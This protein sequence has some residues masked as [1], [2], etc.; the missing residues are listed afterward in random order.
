[1]DRNRIKS[2]ISKMTLEEKASLCSGQDFWHTKRI[3]RLQ[4]PDIMVSDGPSGLRKQDAE[5]D[6]LGVNDSIR[7]VCFP[8]GVTTAAS[9]DLDLME[10]LGRTLGEE[11]Q[12]EDLAILLG[13]AMNIK[14][15]P[16]C[17]RNFEYYSEDPYLSSKLA[18]AY[19]NGL[20]SKQ[21]G[22]CP[23]HFFAN[24]MENHRMTASSEIDERTKREIYLASFEG[25]VKDAKPWSMMCSYNKINGTYAAENEEALSKILRTEWGF[26]GFVMTDWGACNDRVPDL[27]AGLD[28]EMPGSGGA[29]DNKIVKAVKA[30]TLSE[31][32]VDAACERILDIVYRYE[33]HKKTGDQTGIDLKKGHEMAYKVAAN[34][35][36]LLKNEGLLPLRS[37]QQVVFIGKYAQK[38]RY[39]GGGSSHVNNYRIVSALD[40]LKEEASVSF[41]MGYDDSTDEIVEP[42]E[43]EAVKAARNAEAAVLFIGLPNEYESEGYDRKHM[44]LPPNQNHLVEEVCKVQKNVVVVL[45]NGAPVEMPWIGKVGAVLESYLGGQ[46]VGTAQTDIL[47]GKVNPSGHLAESFPI[48]LE[49]NPSYLSF[50]VNHEQVNYMEG[51]Y[52]GYRYYD[53]KN[54]EVLFPFG[55]GLSYTEFVYSDLKISKISMKDTET[56]EVSVT[57][58][59]TGDVYGKEVVQ[60]YVT[61][62]AC[63]VG[64]PE[65]EL[66]GFVKVAL[67]PKESKEVSISLDKRSFAFWNTRIHDWYVASGTYGVKVGSSSRDIRLSGTI[68]VESTTKLISLFSSP[69]KSRMWSSA[70]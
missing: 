24:N 52:V 20:Q 14:R 50:R 25:M 62:A 58:T 27:Q 63:E 43:Q 54:M 17:G 35:M 6:H 15:S 16:L 34:S 13:P 26:D 37:E 55:H 21:I 8:A 7:A 9:F 51:V 33:E 42:L 18:T 22:A 49:D 19:V 68:D 10:E 57:V 44:Q 65:K 31:E 32:I 69:L 70:A 23:K 48:R 12:Q 11:C 28:L 60:F 39:Q 40:A 3:E 29:N 45:H 59:N 56:V 2:L 64:R 1:M 5:A 30:G 47:Y 36:V 4:I 46:A 38:P 66:K 61:P 67:D 53:S 41:Q